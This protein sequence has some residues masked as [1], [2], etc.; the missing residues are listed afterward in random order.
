MK[1]TDCFGSRRGNKMYRGRYCWL[2][3]SEEEGLVGRKGWVG[4]V[5]S[6]DIFLHKN[7]LTQTS[8]PP[9]FNAQCLV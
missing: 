3:V 9:S 1:E 4:D 6:T 5:A 7:R 2:E 8:L